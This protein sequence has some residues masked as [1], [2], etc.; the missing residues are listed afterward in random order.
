MVDQLDQDAVGIV[1]IEGAGSI[2][3]RLRELGASDSVL[4]KTCDPRVHVF[5]LPDHEAN[6]VKSLGADRVLFELVERQIVRARSEINVF[7][8]RLP[9]HPH[10]ENITVKLH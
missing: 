9:L 5:R 10:A 8:V 6:M 7:T 2:T 1:K 4:L 3:M